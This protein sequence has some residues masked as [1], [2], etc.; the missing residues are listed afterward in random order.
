MK[1]H[2]KIFDIGR[3]NEYTVWENEK[4]LFHREDG[5]A[6][7][8]KSGLKEWFLDGNRHREDGP[9]IVWGDG[10]KEWWLDGKKYNE[11]QYK[12]EVFKRNLEK[13]NETI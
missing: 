3:W 12:K 7:I 11:N 2:K 10:T 6:R 13:L 5:P 1:V 9:A 4:G 8:W